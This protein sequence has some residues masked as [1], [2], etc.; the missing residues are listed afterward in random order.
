LEQTRGVWLP[1]ALTMKNRREVGTTSRV[2]HVESDARFIW[3][4][5]KAKSVI[6]SFE[7]PTNRVLKLF[8]HIDA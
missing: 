3:A 1:L 2:H 5:A 4:T 8:L 6:R 7:D